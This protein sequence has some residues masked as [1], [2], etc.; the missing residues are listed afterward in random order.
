MYIIF[1]DKPG[2]A[3]DKETRKADLRPPFCFVF[4]PAYLM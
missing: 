1:L 3:K 4:F 2:R